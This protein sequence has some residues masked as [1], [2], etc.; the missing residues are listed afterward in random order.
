M[1]PEATM[2]A[3][4]SYCCNSFLFPSEKTR[5]VCPESAARP[6][7][8]VGSLHY[9]SF[10]S[11]TGLLLTSPWS[12]LSWFDLW[13]NRDP[14]AQQGCLRQGEVMAHHRNACTD[15]IH[16][17]RRETKTS[18]PRG[19]PALPSASRQSP[20]HGPGSGLLAQPFPPSQQ[21]PWAEAH[22]LLIPEPRALTSPS[23]TLIRTRTTHTPI[24]QRPQLW[25]HLE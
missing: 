6:A 9:G 22:M 2:A 23:Q 24:T 4:S 13:S 11:Y 14:K 25:Q 21:A 18:A 7:Q 17:Y 20:W 10:A 8:P 16:L 12:L 19:V 3:R 5:C 15:H 1:S